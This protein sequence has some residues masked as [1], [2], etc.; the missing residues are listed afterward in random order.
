MS[1]SNAEFHERLAR[2]YRKEAKSGRLGRQS[3][4]INRDGYV[5]VRG[6]GRRRGFP[7]S[8]LMLLVAGFFIIK[9]V[10]MSQFGPDFYVQNVARLDAGTAVEK[11]A[12]FT[13]RPD[14]MSRWVAHQIKTLL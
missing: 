11:A 10:L 7:W 9:G 5:I 4:A 12:A 6:A 3:I 13:L 1:E 8:G 2:I 14:P